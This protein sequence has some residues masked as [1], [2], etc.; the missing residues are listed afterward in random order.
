MR[1]GELLSNLRK[2]R[3]AKRIAQNEI[4]LLIGTSRQ[5]I[6]AVE[7]GKGSTSPPTLANCLQIAKYFGLEG[8]ELSEFLWAAFKE[9]IKNNW[10][11]FDYIEKADGI[12]NLLLSQE[13]EVILAPKTKID[14][15]QNIK[16]D[17]VYQINISI[18]EQRPLIDSSIE[19]YLEGWIAEFVSDTGGE[20]IAFQA[21]KTS[22]ALRLAIPPKFA[23]YDV[24]LGIKDLTSRK[25]KNV[26]DAFSDLGGS[27]WQKGFDVET[28]APAAIAANSAQLVK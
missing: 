18:R 24:V 13:S 10:D 22:I 1:F 14:H 26:S 9:R 23:L 6:D 20:V 19:N 5:Y 21:T 12:P 17:C 27:V 28:K 3:S 25:L 11:F 2:T 7:K 16:Y 8:K 15:I 4:G